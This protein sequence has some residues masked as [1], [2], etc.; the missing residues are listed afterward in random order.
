MNSGVLQ[1]SLGMATSQF[2]GA[3]GKASNVVMGLIGTFVSF[4]AIT[5]GIMDS[6]GKG[7]ALENLHRRTGAAVSDIYQLEQGFKAAGLSGDDVSGTL[8][9]MEKSLGGVNEMGESTPDIFRKMGLSIQ[10]LKKQNAPQQINSIITALGKLGTSDAANAASGIFGRMNAGNIIQLSHSTKDFGAAMADA[11]EEAQNWQRIAP[12]FNDVSSAMAKIKEIGE[13]FFAGIAEGIAP[14]LEAGLKWLES[15]KSGI[16]AIGQGIGKIFTGITEAF[17][18]GKIGELLNLT[19]A[20]SVEFLTN[21]IINTLGSGSFWSGI[22]NVMVGSFVTAFAKVLEILASIG[23]VLTASLDTAFQKFYEAIGKTKIGAALGISG[24]KAET[25][26]QNLDDEKK[27]DA[28]GMEAVKA[29]EGMGQSFF[30]LGAKE[31][32]QVIKTSLANSGGAEQD[33]LKNFWTGLMAKVPALAKSADTTPGGGDL[34]TEKYTYKPDF[35]AFEKMGF[36]SGGASNPATEYA[37]RTADGVQK[38]CGLMETTVNL[39]SGAGGTN[40]NA[41]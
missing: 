7:A 1:F 24:Y 9:N 8:F 11:A 22:F 4:G 32:N 29:I 35:T 10:E 12:L 25:F 31:L 23:Q 5:D 3:I 36:V 39:L 6:I 15:F 21:M 13:G 14:A 30:G 28:G 41:I 18:E 40:Q 37:R 27:R 16:T 34:S 17:R 33:K 19:F 2:I 38:M 26:S 20:A